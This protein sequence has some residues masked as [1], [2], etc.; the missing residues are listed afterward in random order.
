MHTT[1]VHDYTYFQIGFVVTSTIRPDCS[2]I[3]VFLLLCYIHP[4]VM[5]VQILILNVCIYLC[6]I[7]MHWFMRIKNLES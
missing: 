7:V 2:H 3:F 1:I 6:I 5:C 4:L